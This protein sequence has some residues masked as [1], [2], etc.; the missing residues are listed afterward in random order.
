MT[1]TKYKMKK[2]KLFSNSSDNI[3]RKK[4]ELICFIFDY[5]TH[6]Q[7]CDQPIKSKQR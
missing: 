3:S 7:C 6:K 5:I 2:I 1:P 4:E